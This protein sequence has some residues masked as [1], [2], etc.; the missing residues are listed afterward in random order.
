MRTEVFDMPPAPHP[1]TV[2]VYD[3]DNTSLKEG[4]KVLIR[5][6]TKKT[7]SSEESTNSSGVAIVDLANLPI[8]SGQTVPYETGDEVLIISYTP[9]FSEGAY[10]KVTGGSKSQTLYLGRVAY[11][12]NF[13]NAAVKIAAMTAANENAAVKYVK[14]WAIDDGELIEQLEVPANNTV[15]VTYHDPNKRASGGFIVE[16]EAKETVVTVNIR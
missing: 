3:I 16:R 4:A 11:T 2:T 1:V 15:Q 9:K 14:V 10:Y 6:T 13:S 8:A 7:S 12:G 5:N